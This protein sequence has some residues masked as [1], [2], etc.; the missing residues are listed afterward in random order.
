MSPWFSHIDQIYTLQRGGFPFYRDELSLEEW[1]DVGTYKQL[2][3]EEREMN[4][5][6]VL[7]AA[8]A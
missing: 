3:D 1:Q 2:L 6:Q 5:M 8:R 7:M 4:R